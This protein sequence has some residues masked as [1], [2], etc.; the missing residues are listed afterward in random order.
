[1]LVDQ[2]WGGGQYGWSCIPAKGASGGVLMVWSKDSLEVEDVRVE[3][4]SITCRC[5]SKAD[6]FN[7]MITGLYGP[8]DDGTHEYFN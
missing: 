5:K 4:F 2:V 6:G 8:N 3:A 7:W 1:M